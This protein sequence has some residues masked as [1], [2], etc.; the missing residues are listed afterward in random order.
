MYRTRIYFILL[1]ISFYLNSCGKLDTS[2]P[3]RFRGFRDLE[4]SLFGGSGLFLIPPGGS[5]GVSGTSGA[6]GASGA[7]GWNKLLFR[8]QLYPGTNCTV[9][10]YFV[11]FVPQYRVTVRVPS[12]HYNYYNI[13]GSVAVLIVR[14]QFHS[15]IDIIKR[16]YLSCTQLPFM[17]TVYTKPSDI[18]LFF[19]EIKSINSGILQIN[20]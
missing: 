15:S 4:V 13:D 10:Y 3:G 11:E 20:K 7:T 14:V 8:C 1:T 17:R 5:S 2:S 19:S 12:T 9:R 6:A 18:R 16:R